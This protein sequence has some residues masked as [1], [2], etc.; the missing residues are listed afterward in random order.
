[1]GNFLYC[2]KCIHAAFG[3]SKQRLARQ[4]KMNQ[5]AS[6]EPITHL[7]KA[8]VEEKQLGEF[9]VMPSGCDEAF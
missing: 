3:I 6:Q 8:E 7:T 2:A 9:V 4:R 5:S 1:M